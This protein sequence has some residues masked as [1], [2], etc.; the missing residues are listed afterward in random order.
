MSEVFRRA[1]AQG[2]KEG[3]RRA[4]EEIDDAELDELVERIGGP[5]AMVRFLVQRR[6]VLDPEPISSTT[7]W[8]RAHLGEAEPIHLLDVAP[9]L[10]AAEAGGHE[11]IA[12]RLRM[13]QQFLQPPDPMRWSR[14]VPS[15]EE[16]GFW[17]A[18]AE[19]RVEE[20]LASLDARPE[21]ATAVDARGLDGVALASPHGDAT[22]ELVTALAEA[23]ARP[24]ART[25]GLIARSGSVSL[26][27]WLL[28]RGW[29]V[30]EHIDDD[31]LEVAVGS[32]RDVAGV[33]ERLVHAGA[34]PNGCDRWGV[35]VWGAS[36][37]RH[38]S[39]LERLG[40]RP[41]PSGPATYDPDTGMSARLAA[42]C[43][44]DAVDEGEADLNEAAAAGD[45]AQVEA[46]LDEYGQ[47]PRLCRDGPVERPMHLAAYMGRGD[48]IHRLIACGYSP[49]EINAPVGRGH[50]VG[51]ASTWGQSAVAVAAAR[52]MDEAIYVLMNSVDFVQGRRARRK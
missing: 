30:R 31:A 16:A 50:H 18:C 14:P 34:D 23:G 33:A 43:R 25:L 11:E 10:A 3:A 17:R 35:S 42:I 37:P 5:R 41:E 32:E 47:Q 36:A 44:G 48:V 24:S 45:V 49:A 22:S 1:C 29:P 26:V 40:A 52:G 46:R 20:A 39:A 19:G 4:L 27:E 6:H 2:D 28:D 8:V 51:P 13:H 7:A 9:A 21:L 15:E 38:R 12:R